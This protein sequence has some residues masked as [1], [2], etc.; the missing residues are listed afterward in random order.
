MVRIEHRP[1]VCAEF[2]RKQEKMLNFRPPQR[3]SQ[4][5]RLAFAD[6]SFKLECACRR[7]LRM[8]PGLSHACYVYQNLPSLVTNGQ[9]PGIP[10]RTCS[11]LF[12]FILLRDYCRSSKMLPQAAT[13]PILTLLEMRHHRCNPAANLPKTRVPRASPKERP[14]RARCLRVSAAG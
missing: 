5:L 12:P 9:R 4:R 3:P 6:S 10:H 13:N 11:R 7:W 14:F 2:G 8:R 1:G